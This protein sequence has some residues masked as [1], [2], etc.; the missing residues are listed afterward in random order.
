MKIL[1]VD[2]E[3][4]DLYISKKILGMEFQ[5]EGFNN[6][7]EAVEWAKNNSFDLLVSDYYLGKGLHAHDVLKALV[8][9]KGKV[10][11]SFVL[12]NYIDDHKVAELMQAGFNG[13]ID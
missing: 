13:I 3:M 8:E 5:V 1:V 2:D 4:L 7:P 10:F 12:T 6:L 11:K 9:V